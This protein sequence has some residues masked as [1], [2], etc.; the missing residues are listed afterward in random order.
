[1]LLRWKE[2]R[3]L[4][5]LS[6]ALG[7]VHVGYNLTGFIDTALA[8]RVGGVTLAATGLGSGVFF[9]VSVFGIGAVLGLEPI[10]AQA[11]GAERPRHARV[12]LWQGFYVAGIVTL[13]LSIVIMV[14]GWNL[15][16]FGVEEELAAE[17]LRYL[18]G[19]VFS[20][21]PLLACVAIRVY[22]Q[23]MHRTRPVVLAVIG[24]NLFNLVADWV[25]IFGDE[26]LVQI[27]L[28]ALGI[29]P[30]GVAGVGW[31]ST[32]ATL[33][34]IAVLALA[35]R[36]LPANDGRASVRSLDLAVLKQTLAVG[37]PLAFQLVAEV[38]IFA[39]V[40]L[41]MANMG[42]TTMASHQVALQWAA[43]TFGV[44]LGI[45]SATAVQVGRAIGRGDAPETRRAGL[46]GIGIGAVFMLGAALLFWLWPTGLARIMTSDPEV[47]PGAAALLLIA[48]VF[49]VADGVQAVAGGAL[50]GAGVTRFTFVTHLVGHWT[51]GMPVGVGLA[52][53]AGMG[54]AGLWWGLTAGLSVVALTLA[55]EFSLLSRRSIS[56][57]G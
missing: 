8:G 40:G 33:G 22:L 21:W 37:L 20:L 57:L 47:I 31:S 1:M 55:I 51:I 32:V 44:S 52:Y 38:G 36:R 24:F 56:Q 41:M 5:R 25:L 30:L 35:V 49:Q 18:V 27:G 6:A 26:G 4:I 28:P 12:V 53:G 54:P 16:L 42:T 17:T 15:D 43:L 50:R 10:I 19:R 7:F 13:P 3:E 46:S 39:L 45:G 23:G 2:L 29:P 9:V 34:Q 11:F 48:A 14:L